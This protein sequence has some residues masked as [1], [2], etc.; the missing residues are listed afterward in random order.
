LGKATIFNI[1]RGQGNPAIDT[2]WALAR[3]LEV[4]IGALFIDSDLATIEVLRYKQAPVLSDGH[5]HGLEHANGGLTDTDQQRVSPEGAG[6]VSRHLVSTRGSRPC[7]LYWVDM[8]ADVTRESEP[9]TLGIIEH[10]VP[11]IGQLNICVGPDITSLAAGDRITF[12]ADRWHSYETVG[13]E[14]K[15]LVVIDYP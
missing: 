1:E 2:L 11:I 14:A 3:A 8:A 7:E 10:V 5:S 9:H 4:P 6:F 15:F 13:H 12:R